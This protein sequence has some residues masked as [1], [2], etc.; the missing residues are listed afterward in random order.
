MKEVLFF[1][2]SVAHILIWAFVLLAF[3]NPKTAKI[4][5]YFVVPAIYIIHLLPFHLLSWA[6][7]SLYPDSSE[8]RFDGIKSA[9]VIPAIYDK[10]Q[11]SLGNYCMFNPLSPQGMLIFG[12]I[13]SIYAIHLSELKEQRNRKNKL[14]LK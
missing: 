7:D 1:L 8:A 3:I 12:L 9:L 13:T 10:V 5:A 2:V 11:T 6:K 4:N 14:A